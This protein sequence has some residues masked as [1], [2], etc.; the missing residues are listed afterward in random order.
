[1]KKTIIL[2]CTILLVI[3]T[4]FVVQ[5][6]NY[7]TENQRLQ[8]Q[9]EVYEAYNG[10]T[11]FGNDVATIINK[12]ADDNQKNTQKIEV[13]IQFLE[14]DDTYSSEQ[15]LKQGIEKFIQNYGSRTFKCSNID[16][17]GKRITTIWIEEISIH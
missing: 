13:K 6:K 2:I 15:I 5:V 7:N 3:I 10:K 1:M 11:I 16:Y 17:D 14:S 8:R 4:I 12:V 9:K